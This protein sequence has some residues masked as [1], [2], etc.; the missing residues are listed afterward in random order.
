MADSDGGV[1]GEVAGGPSGEHGVFYIAEVTDDA[2]V[3][4]TRAFRTGIGCGLSGLNDDVD[5]PLVRDGD[6]FD[7]FVLQGDESIGHFHG[8][9]AGGGDGRIDVGASESDD[10]GTVLVFL[11]VF[12]N[13]TEGAL[14]MQGDEKVNRSGFVG[15]SVGDFV[16]EFGE[17]FCP[18][19]G[20]GAISGS[21]E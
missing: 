4:I 9:M 1:I 8:A 14:G 16:A 15:G 12:L 19:S 20:S 18:L 21:L 13:G 17:E 5:F 7:R 6:L 10:E 3:E 2:D 11:A